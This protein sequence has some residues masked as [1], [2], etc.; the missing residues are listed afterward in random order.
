M[1]NL[2][3]LLSVYIL[4]FRRIFHRYGPGYSDS[5]YHGKDCPVCGSNAAL[6]RRGMLWPELI[7]QWKLSPAWANWIDQREGLH[8]CNCKANLRSRQLAQ[9]ITDTMNNRLNINAK[10]LAELCNMSQMQTQVIAETNAAGELHTFLSNL[11]ELHYSEYGSN[12][13]EVPS[14]DLQNL[15]Y[16][17]NYFDLV[18]N[19]DVLEHVP[20]VKLALAEI[21]RVLKPN[22][23]YIFSVPVIWNQAH[24]RCRAS[25]RDGELIH[26]LPPSYHG[27][28]QE[29]RKDFIVF[30]E[31]GR[32]FIQTCEDSG[33]SIGLVKDSKNPALV[34]FIANRKN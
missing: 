15:S 2:L 23:A 7:L 28:E 32:D 21:H 4:K 9:C 29:G 30:H 24:T 12:D 6:V 20:D 5:H 26:I 13:P 27:A 19:S 17:D 25:L 10:N 14:E 1:N 18:V 3:Y 33:F 31:F 16:S 8:C 11:K 34:T 22:G